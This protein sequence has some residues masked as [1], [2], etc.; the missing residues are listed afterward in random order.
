MA[1]LDTLR[2]ATPVL[3]HANRWNHLA[4]YA[5][6]WLPAAMMALYLKYMIM[7]Q[8]GFLVVTRST[9]R[10]DGLPYLDQL[11][12]FQ[13]DILITL[14]IIPLAIMLLCHFIAPRWRGSIAAAISIAFVLLFYGNMQS[15]GNIGRSLSFDLLTDAIRWGIGHPVYISEYI[16]FKGFVKFVLV[17]AIIVISAWWASR[18]DC[19]LHPRAPRRKATVLLP[20]L[21]A[22]TLVVAV[23]AAFSHVTATLYHENIL[24]KSLGDFFENEELDL[25]GTATIGSEKVLSQFLEFTRTPLHEKDSRYF[26]KAAGDDVVLVIFE[27]GPHRA[28]SIDKSLEGF[29]NLARLRRTA[30]VGA[31]HYSTYPYTSPAH[32]SILSGLYPLELK[33]EKLLRRYPDIKLP[34][35]MGSL[36]SQGYETAIYGPYYARFEQDEKMYHALGVNKLVIVEK[37]PRLAEVKQHDWCSATRMLDLAALEEMKKDIAQLVKDNR[38]FF[39]AFMPQIGHAPWCD[40]ANNRDNYVARGRALM[41]MQDAWIGEIIE[42]LEANKRLNKTVIVITADHGIRT[43]QEDPTF[44][45]GMIDDYSFH[46]PLLVFAKRAFPST[47]AVP[48]V[49]SHIDIAPTVLDLLGV[50]HGRRYEQ[51]NPI[52]DA[53]LANRITYFFAKGYL[54]A[55]GVHADGKFAMLNHMSGAVYENDIMKF[56]AEHILPTDSTR[57]QDIVTAIKAVRPL[58]DGWNHVAI[59]ASE[60]GKGGAANE[61]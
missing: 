25:T 5:V 59:I 58:V 38:R 49:T 34:G 28:L 27:T 37:L 48:W 23:A 42:L 33:F 44:K 13:Y 43:R 32:F 50:E 61:P 53:R 45:G 22:P 35:L 30:I 17:V 40:I 55:D 57:R 14:V 21:L 15:H 8:R 54:G 60:A 1:L 3:K 12:F 29:P 24:G 18:S 39:A 11:S 36:R 6:V 51:G 20:A 16:E 31:E 26:G 19:D 7:S 52:W 47:V 46:V 56:D 4:N 41:A 10:M 9:G 2:A